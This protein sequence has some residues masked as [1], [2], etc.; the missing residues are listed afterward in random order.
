MV[1]D[2]LISGIVPLCVTLAGEH[3]IRAPKAT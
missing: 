2:V 1:D 3:I